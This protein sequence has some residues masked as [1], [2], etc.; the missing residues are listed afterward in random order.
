[1]RPRRKDSAVNFLRTIDGNLIAEHEVGK[2]DALDESYAPHQTIYTVSDLR[3]SAEPSERA[4]PREVERF[5]D[6]CEGRP[7]RVYASDFAA[8]KK[9]KGKRR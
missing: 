6:A 5:V 3:N 9:K 1:M 2:I 8:A 7:T 4:M